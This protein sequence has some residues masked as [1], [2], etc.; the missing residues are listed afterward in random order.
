MTPGLRV[1]EIAA[2]LGFGDALY[3]SRLFRAKVG[4]SPQQYRRKM[5]TAQ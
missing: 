1:K 3:F 2:G 5:L 4:L